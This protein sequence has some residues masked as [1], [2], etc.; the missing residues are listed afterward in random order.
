MFSKDEQK[1]LD[2]IQKLQL[3][4]RQDS[5]NDQIGDL[6]ILANIFGLY[7]AAEYVFIN[8]FRSNRKPSEVNS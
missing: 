6:I 4:Q 7:G 5:L 2:E 3:P 8:T 1:H